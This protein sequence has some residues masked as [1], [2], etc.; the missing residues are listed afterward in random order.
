MEKIG[1]NAYEYRLLFAALCAI[2][3]NVGIE[4]L[5]YRFFTG[6]MERIALL[7]G[8]PPDAFIKCL[9]PSGNRHLFAF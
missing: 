1:H 2:F 6:F 8:K 5:D 3:I 4:I 9:F 7:P